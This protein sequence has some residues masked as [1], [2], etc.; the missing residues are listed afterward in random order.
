MLT[1]HK[2]KKLFRK[3]FR[4][5]QALAFSIVLPRLNYFPW[6]SDARNFLWGSEQDDRTRRADS[7]PFFKEGNMRLLRLQR[8]NL[9][10][11]STEII[12]DPEGW[13]IGGIVHIH[14]ANIGHTRKQ[15]FGNFP[16][17]GVYSDDVI[18]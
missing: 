12:A 3:G 15:V 5:S 4:F 1:L 14:P 10:N 17:P 2:P 11:R 7:P 8:F 9:D 16:R 6:G 13:R 18:I